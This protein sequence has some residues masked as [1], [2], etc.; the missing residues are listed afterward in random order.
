MES[1]LPNLIVEW[2]PYNM[3][4]NITYLTRGG[5]SEI[6]SADWVDG[7]YCKWELDVMV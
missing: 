4:K 5:F 2:I 7:N 6:Y 3:L 1:P